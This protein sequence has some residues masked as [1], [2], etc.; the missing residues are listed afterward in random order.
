MGARVFAVDDQGN[1]YAQAGTNIIVINAT[2]EAVAT[3][4]LSRYPGKAQRDSAG[5]LYYAGVY[6]AE[7]IGP[8]YYT[9]PACFLAK[10]NSEGSL[11]WITN[12]GPTGIRGVEMMDLRL[13]AEG[14]AYMGYTF[15]ITT[16][17]HHDHVI[18]INSQGQKVYLVEPPQPQ[19]FQTTRGTVRL[20]P[21]SN[22]RVYA[23][24]MKNPDPYFLAMLSRIDSNGGITVVTNWGF[25]SLF[26][27][28]VSRTAEN[29]LGEYYNVES[30]FP[31]G[32]YRLTKRGSDDGVLWERVLNNSY[33]ALAPD[34]FNGVHLGHENGALL[35]YDHEG[36]LAWSNNFGSACNSLILD[37]S[38]HRFLS[39]ADGRVA[40]LDD[41]IQTA[42]NIVTGPAG[43]TVLAG[44]NA[45]FQVSATGFG[46]LHYYWLLN[47]SPLAAQTNTS[48][49]LS[50]V[51]TAQGG[52]YSV[53][54]SNSI[55]SITSPPALLRVRNVA[56]FFGNQLLTN[57]TYAFESAPT[58]QIRSAY[59]N[60]SI[61]YTLNGNTP[62]FSSIPYSGPFTLS[63]S[64]LVRAIG[65]SADFLQSEESDAV[66]IFVMINHTLTATAGPGGSISLN[67]PGGTYIYTNIVSVTATPNAG[68]SFLY[69]LGDASG[70]NPTV[71]LSMSQDRSVHAVFGTTLSTTV[72]GNGQIL[73]HPPGGLYPHGTVV[74]LTAL[75]QPGHYFGAWGNAASGN[76]NPLYFTLTDPAPTVSSIFAPV[77]ADQAAL[78]VLIE[79]AGRVTVSPRANI[80]PTNQTVNLTAVPDPGQI[81]LNWSG[82]ATG[83][84]NPINVQV[85][86]TKLIT[87]NFSNRPRLRV[88]RPG[89]EGMT[90]SGFRFTL[91]G[92]GPTSWQI[93][94]SSNLATWEALGS[95]T[96]SLGEVQFTDP[97]ALN[98]NHRF[99]RA[100]NE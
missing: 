71:N 29:S 1:S 57:G 59:P 28:F 64:A 99:Y 96:N 42:P 46:P 63:S 11:Q 84:I 43:Q 20:T 17:S 55:S 65:Y 91:S 70:T 45:V 90:P 98:R 66:D 72:A 47:G 26:A 69:W 77:P 30:V 34:Q 75:P 25:N 8:F 83:S 22:N 92:G 100:V 4:S 37:D 68:W 14:N 23:L 48:L 62:S 60:G 15:N 18:K 44:S 41:E 88:D 56:V 97:A 86:Q 2:G 81:F 3:H 35:R 87:A 38:G 32:S 54:V 24:T 52:L 36:N 79:G 5:N 33:F 9:N 10:Y 74:R 49:T 50:N 53:I 95:V 6:P 85:N 58:L 89:L 94:G 73:L 39:F 93:H 21:L 82:D 16:Y 80:Y 27:M 7:G 67:P 51:T 31:N 78:T 12:V 19:L 76:T 40:R 13:D 61:Y